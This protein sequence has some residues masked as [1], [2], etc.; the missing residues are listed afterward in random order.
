MRVAVDDAEA[1]G[2]TS[3]RL[4]WGSEQIELA[5]IRIGQP[6]KGISHNGCQVLD[7]FACVSQGSEG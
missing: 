2:V 6:C 7:K 4:S 5:I 3:R 1:W